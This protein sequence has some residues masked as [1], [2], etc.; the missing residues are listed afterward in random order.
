[1][2]RKAFGSRPRQRTVEMDGGTN[3][4]ATALSLTG[5]LV[6]SKMSP[7]GNHRRPHRGGHHERR[8]HG[9]SSRHQSPSRRP[10]RQAHLLDPR[11]VRGVVPQVV[12]PLPGGRPR[13]PL[14]PDAGQPPGRPAHPAR[15]GAHHP[16]DPPSAPGPCLAGDAIQP[17]RDQGHP[18]RAEGPE[19]PA[20]PRRGPSSACCSAT[21]E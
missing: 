12:A 9:A 20:A 19:Y 13:G 16:I 21:A 10:A 1:M 8:L 3:T 5:L 11:P 7:A 15:V 18:R 4:P 2:S 6:A 14:R 17:D